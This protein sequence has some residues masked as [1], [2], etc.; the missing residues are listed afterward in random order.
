[1]HTYFA[2]HTAQMDVDAATRQLLWDRRL[3]AIHHPNDR[4]RELVEHDNPSTDPAEYSGSARTA[5]TILREMSK[6]GGYVCAQYHG[7]TNSLVGVVEPG[8]PVEL[9]VGTWGDRY[10]RSG[11]SAVLK[12]V[13][14][15]RVKEVNPADC[16]TI[17]VGRPRM[18]T[19][20]R[21]WRAGRVIENLV[22]G[23]H[24]ATT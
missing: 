8:T 18:G 15:Q 21:W 12:A 17:L 5:M 22:N 10:G 14:M 6:S 2:R 7:R 13:G 24:Q 23:V 9:V 20:H 19:L 1:M 16:A 4:N 3:V 11:R